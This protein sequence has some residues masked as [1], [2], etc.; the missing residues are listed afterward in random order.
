VKC[1]HGCTSGQL[2][3]EALF[4]LQARGIDKDS[5]QGMLLYAF[6]G[7]VLDAITIPGVKDYLEKVIS[8]RLHQNN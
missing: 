3:E 2:D 1:S 8:L 5:A 4:Y 6:V 7:E